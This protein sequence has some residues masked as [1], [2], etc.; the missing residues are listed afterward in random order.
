MVR[1]QVTYTG[2]TF[3]D[4]FLATGSSNNPVGSDL[5]G[6]NFGGAGALVVAPVS[7]A[8]GEFQSIIKFNLSNAVSLFNTSYGTNNWTIT[9]I[10]LEL[11]SNYGTN[12]VQP[13]NLMFPVISGGKFVIEW[14][15]ND[16]WVEGTGRPI[17]PTTNGVTYNS[18]P[19]LLS[20]THEILC[21]NTYAPPGNNV[22]VTWTLPLN[23]NLVADVAGGGDVS[24]LFYA[25]DDQIG[26]LFNPHTFPGNEPLI[27]VT[28]ALNAAQ[29]EIVSGYFTNAN[30][31]LAGLGAPNLEYQIQATTSLATTN[32][33]AL[34]TVTA[35]GAG[36]ILFDDLTAT[37]QLQR[38][39]RLSR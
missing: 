21:T 9:V 1:S 34:G 16:D 12:N 29:L 11:A 6:L 4:A 24:F 26:Y 32:W 36:M 27:H 22:Y 19:D 25:A 14:L 18:L 15:S 28:A 35:D 3:A 17:Q 31:H 30:F 38:F 23:S 5:T 8:K 7:S 39:Y 20:T 2:T 33:Q 10:S 13:D 37:N